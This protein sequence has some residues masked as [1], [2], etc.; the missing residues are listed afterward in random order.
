[1][2]LSRDNKGYF[3][4]WFAAATFLGSF[5]YFQIQ[6]VLCKM[7]IPA[8]GGGAAVWTSCMLFFQV[9]LIAGY[10]YV[11]GVARLAPRAQVAIHLSLL[12][13]SLLF[14]PADLTGH[15]DGRESASPVV[16]ILMKLLFSV[17][18]P[19]L[20]LAA[21]APIVQSWFFRSTAGSLPWT[22]YAYSNAG[23]LVALLSYPIIVERRLHIGGQLLFWKS[24]YVIYCLACGLCA[25]LLLRRGGSATGIAAEMESYADARPC[26]RT[27]VI[28]WVLAAATGS[29]LL[30]SITEQILLEVAP[31]P[32]LWVVPFS[33]YLATYIICFGLKR[34]YGTLTNSV[35]VIAAALAAPLALTVGNGWGIK[36]QVLL[37]LVALGSSC[38]LCHGDIVRMRP[39]PSRLAGFYIA[40][41]VGGC[42]G[43]VFVNLLVPLVFKA[44]VETPFIIIAAL[45]V[46]GS[47]HYVKRDGLPARRSLLIAAGASVVCLLAFSGFYVSRII[48]GGVA[49][50][51]NFFGT[52]KVVRERDAVGAKMVLEHGTTVHGSQY[53]DMS[54]KSRTTTYYGPYTAA[55]LALRFHP[56]RV[57][58]GEMGS[59]RVGV[60]GL[61]V[62]TLAA[63][64]ASGDMFRFYEINPDVIRLAREK[65]SFLA[66][67][68]ARIEIVTGDARMSLERELREGMNQQFD[69]LVVDAFNSDSIPV[70]LA[71]RE[72]IGVYLRHLAPG[73][74]LLFHISNR[75]LDLMPVVV[76][77]AAHNG[78]NALKV[79]TPAEPDEG[80]LESTWALLTNNT[81]VL[82]NP[83][84]RSRSRYQLPD[85]IKWTDRFA[86][87]WQI[88]K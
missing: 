59:L 33:V 22:L 56:R 8:Y 63:Y 43:G 82:N 40:I 62:G 29:A 55:G 17:G 7:I 47:A 36:V 18:A 30:L 45:V 11:A 54:L 65:F 1:M 21:S 50:S 13:V 67:S 20:L 49:Y 42:L 79:V 70:H 53:I 25:L 81:A 58:A 68:G 86:G 66:D 16:S 61:G 19:G 32:F 44:H 38:M 4:I 46:H 73:G 52:L 26:R 34:P 9:L 83:E 60:I 3:C 51:R 35:F 41:A 76:E 88:M 75:N 2:E 64:A 39:H 69:V 31:V 27:E 48:S 37:F 5:L 10:C 84:I 14:L 85:G 15:L 6:P 72:A 57:L 28:L 24:L 80:R 74:I 87:L 12:T 78:L 77:H 71:T 23:S